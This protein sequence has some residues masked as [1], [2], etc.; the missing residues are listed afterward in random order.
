M[1]PDSHTIS[2]GDLVNGP[3]GE[4]I[5]V[6]KYGNGSYDIDLLAI[7]EET[8][9]RSEIITGRIDLL[10]LDIDTLFDLLSKLDPVVTEPLLTGQC[11]MGD[12]AQF[13]QFMRKCCQIFVSPDVI[14]HLHCRAFAAYDSA[15]EFLHIFRNIPQKS[16]APQFGFWS[17]LAWAISYCEFARCYS[18]SSHQKAAALSLRHLIPQFR[19]DTKKLWDICKMFKRSAKGGT[20]MKSAL[21]TYALLYFSD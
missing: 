15:R 6:V 16:L 7:Y 4:P 8:P 2:L 13:E 17:N 5:I 1:K 21:D 20:R 3:I 10:A 11:I 12:A 9:P 19:S 14:S 18:R